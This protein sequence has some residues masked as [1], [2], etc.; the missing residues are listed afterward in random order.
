MTT[1]TLI[2]Q[3]KW[4]LWSLWLF[5]GLSVLQPSDDVF[6]FI[7]FAAILPLTPYLYW[8][9]REHEQHL[10]RSLAPGATLLLFLFIS[11]SWSSHESESVSRYI[12]WFLETLVFFAAA[13]WCGYQARRENLAFGK[14]LHFIVLIAGLGS[15]G[16]YIYQGHYPARLEGIGLLGHPVLGSSVLISLW[17]LGTLDKKMYVKRLLWLLVG[18]AVAV[19]TF[20]YLTQSR[21]PL[22][23][24]CGFLLCIMAL[25]LLKKGRARSWGIALMAVFVVGAGVAIVTETPLLASMVERG[26]SYRFEI[27]STII[28]HWR[29]FWLTGV[30]IATPFPASE[31]GQA[32]R[33]ATQQT[34]VHPHNIL[35]SMWFFAGLPGL[36]LFLGFIIHLFARLWLSVKGPW[37]GLGVSV[38]LVVMALCFTDTYRLISS[39]RPMWVIFWLPLGFLL[40]WSVAWRQRSEVVARH[41]QVTQQGQG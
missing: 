9:S 34:I 4:L 20:V 14:Y 6:R 38:L 26:D 18:S 17:A 32:L 41:S 35:I 40:G 19:I 8:C 1:K 28:G 29:S 7:Y 27:W 15:V 24:L 5:L 2:G 23:A 37:R 39:P 13:A 36:L 25:L 11:V 21:G 10:L 16:L 12:R 22:L 3:G 33:E 30:G 31:A